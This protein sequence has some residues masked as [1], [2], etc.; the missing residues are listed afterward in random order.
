MELLNSLKNYKKSYI[1]NDILSGLLVAIIAMPLSIALGLQSVPGSSG[2]QMGII[3]AIIAGFIVSVFGGSR[4][5]IGGPTAAF[6]TIIFGYISNESIGL[7]GLQFATLF[8]GVILIVLGLL[9]C[10]NLVKFIPYPIIVGFTTGIGITLLF[11]QLKDICGF[12]GGGT[13]FLDKVI[14]YVTTITSFN[15]PTFLLGTCALASIYLI[16]KINK[17]LPSAFISIVLFTLVNVLIKGES[18]GIKTIGSTYGNIS[19]TI[20]FASFSGVENLNFLNIIIPTIVIAFLGGLESLL[21]ATVADGMTKLKSNYNQELIGQGLG[22]IGSIMFG[23]LP[24]TGAIAR[25]SANINSG[26][27][28][29][30]AGAFHAIFLLIMYFAL[31]SVIKFIPLCALS[32]VLINVS[33]NIC[34]PKLFARLTMFGKRDFL[35]LYTTMLLTVFFDLTYGVVG[36]F[37]LAILLN[38]KILKNGIKT[39]KNEENSNVKYELFGSLYFFNVNGLISSIKNDLLAEKT[40]A[41]DL[42]NLNNIDLTA[43]EK[44]S[45]LGNHITLENA[46]KIVGKRIEKYFL[47]V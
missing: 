2:I 46:N 44:L 15:L 19:A 35:I 26:A 39:V 9:K 12:T 21:S 43:I 6:V 10:G 24:A 18:L 47:N 8:A 36:G 38:V 32:A 45:S 20:N 17:K 31:M 28:S 3:T 29:S 30:L 1:V 40:V 13:H 27:K 37:A 7:I 42:K 41:L 22:N 4:F 25:T 5:Q 23:G 34:N 16:S 11:G 14:G 33:I